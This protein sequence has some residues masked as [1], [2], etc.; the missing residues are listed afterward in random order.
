[1][2]T[3]YVGQLRQGGTCAQRLHAL[4]NLVGEVHTLDTEEPEPGWALGQTRRVA[5]R[6]RRPLDIGDVNSRLINLVEDHKPQL[7]WIDKGNVIK[8][9]TL[10]LLKKQPDP[11]FL[12]SYSPDDMSNPRNTSAFYE[13]TIHLYDLHVT[14]KSYNVPELQERGAK[15]A[16]FV[17]NAFDPLTHRP[18]SDSTELYDVVFVGTWE[19]ARYKSLLAL[20]GAGVTVD[21]WGGGWERFVDVSPNLRVHS[22]GVF[23]DEYARVLSNAR[24]ALC[25][26]RKATRDLQTT[27][28]VEIPACG[29]LMIAERTEEHLG[30]FREGTEAVYFRDNVE[31]VER[32][33]YFLGHEE[34]RRAIALAGHQRAWSEPYSYQAQLTR[35]LQEIE[36]LVSPEAPERTRAYPARRDFNRKGSRTL[37]DGLGPAQSLSDGRRSPER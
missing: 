8:P 35:V 25:F 13:R 9:Q 27:R 17:D 18:I 4:R 5:H 10:T 36:A 34:K 12:V 1:M 30:L 31:L 14:T 23:G 20:A 21:I 19:K 32:V 11:P 33:H 26:L 15:R 22:A 7:V 28:S 3:V 37:I 24:I 2:K 6:L 16:L 29:P